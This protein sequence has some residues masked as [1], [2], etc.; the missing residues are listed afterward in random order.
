MPATVGAYRIVG[1]LGRGGMG[2]VL[3]GEHMETGES[4]AVKTV[5]APVENALSGIRREIHA[6][7]RVRHPGIVRIVDQGLADGRPWYAMQL[8]DGSTLRDRIDD[9]W[10]HPP[11]GGP[12]TVDVSSTLPAEVASSAPTAPEIVTGP[13]EDLTSATTSPIQ[14]GPRDRVEPEERPLPGHRHRSPIALMELLSLARRLCAPLGFLHGSG[15]VHRDLKPDNI[16]VRADGRPVLVDLGIAACFGGAASREELEADDR[17]M[18]TVS[19]M[20]PEQIRGELVDARADLYALG[21]ILYECATG[22]PPFT[23]AKNASILYQHLLEQPVRPSAR[24]LDVPPALDRLILELLEKRPEDRLGYADDVAAALGALGAEGGPDDGP[25]PRAYL[26]RP[27]MAGRDEPLQRLDGAVDRLDREGRGGLV[28][29]HGVSGVGKTRLSMEMAR[30]AAQRGL[31]VI[32]GQCA[33]L[34][35]GRA[36]LH[37]LR[38]LLLTVA[39]RAGRRG[40]AAVA[41][42]LGPRAKVLAAYEPALL[43]L[44]GLERVPDPPPLGPEAARARV[45]DSLAGTLFALAG[46]V[47]VV[48]VLDDL[49]WA[50]E[51]SLSVLAKLAASDLDRHRVLVVG[52]YRMEETRPELDALAQAKGAVSIALDRLDAPD[53][54][55][56]VSGMLGLAEPPARLLELLVPRAGGNPFFVAEYLHAAIAEGMLARDRAGRWQW[57][58]RGGTAGALASL[59]LP[60]TFAELFD[61]R[62]GGLDASGRALVAWAS[63]LGRDL[64][65]DL[66]AS[67]DDAGDFDAIEALRVRQILEETPGGRLRFVHDKIRELAYERLGAAERQTLHARAAAVLEARAAADPDTWSAIAHHH[68]EAGAHDRA[69]RYLTRAAERARK[70]YA[71]AQAIALYR[72]AIAEGRAAGEAGVPAEELD[73]R[74]ALHEALG[75]VLSLVG[76]RRAAR[77]ALGEALEEVPPARR[78]E[79]AR[80]L[81]KLAKTW[82]TE[83]QPK[84]ALRSYGEAEE[85]L[86]PS[87]DEAAEPEEAWWHQWV[88]LQV[89]RVWAHYW[90]ADLEG[91]TACVERARPEVERRGTPAQR[92]R[93]FQA[94]GHGDFRRERYA[95]TA[96]TVAL[97]RA[98]LAAAEATDDAGGIAYARFVLGFTLVFAG[99]LDEAGPVLASALREAEHTG[100]RALQARCLT[101]LTLLHRLRGEAAETRSWAHAALAVAL[102]LEMHDYIG[103]AYANL[104]WAAWVEG[105]A[106]TAASETETALAHWARLASK[107]AYPLQWMARLQGMAMALAREAVD[108]AVEHA[109]MIGGAI[110]HRLPAE[111]LGPLAEAVAAFD[112]GSAAAAAPALQRALAA[113]AGTARGRFV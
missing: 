45:I 100:D 78:V 28:L 40:A 24:A 62:L 95:L 43:G 34:A 1:L 23:G 16:F 42:M 90:L 99:G 61:R 64:D 71:N 83:H 107:F 8:L 103:A 41:E 56:M 63:V 73:P 20:A 91:M 32:T 89:E 27:E 29:V 67:P 47:K 22:R 113:A 14:G 30:G 86:G 13:P 75:D 59:P 87:P 19:Y 93:F 88:A 55:A 53:V 84:E 38:P 94:I 36:P 25:P 110:Q 21:C 65:A 18:G 112:E 68:A 39:D 104:G 3:R 70:R 52:T 44:S 7:G 9:R 33:A 66:L 46:M 74:G 6:L 79:R 48:L 81:S 10:Q 82:E 85:A 97:M 108:E 98:S 11:A 4:V 96:S 72:R 57:N 105:D 50:D 49:Q 111:V 109:R 12:T 54:G 106:T 17:V 60:E 2:V 69:S 77:E 5:R 15:L 51:L 35:A 26:Y 80:L 31:A 92:A 76:Q 58:E 37:A 101:Y 102:D